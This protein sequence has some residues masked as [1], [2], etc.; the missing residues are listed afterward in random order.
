[1]KEPPVGGLGLLHRQITYYNYCWQ[2]RHSDQSGKRGKKRPS[3]AMAAKRTGHVWS[4]AELFEAVMPSK[5]A[6]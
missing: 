5:V 1:M 6:A 4:F 3:A 2:T